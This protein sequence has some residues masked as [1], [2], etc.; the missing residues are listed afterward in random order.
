MNETQD[1]DDEINRYR[2]CPKDSL[3]AKNMRIYLKLPEGWYE[4]HP[5]E[6]K[7]MPPYWNE[8]R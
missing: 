8:F 4:E 2:W 3:Y 7:S 6:I 5:A 1:V